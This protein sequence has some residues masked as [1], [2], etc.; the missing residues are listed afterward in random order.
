MKN[1]A[2]TVHMP[3]VWAAFRF[4]RTQVSGKQGQGQGQLTV[5]R[6]PHAWRTGGRGGGQSAEMLATSGPHARGALTALPLTATCF[7]LWTWTVANTDDHRISQIT[8][9]HEKK[10]TWHQNSR[11]KIR[12]GKKT[13]PTYSRV[14]LENAARGAQRLTRVILQ[15]RPILTSKLQNPPF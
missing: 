14:V 10:K 13:P 3:S 5:A 2:V 6:T 9:P 12:E 1:G 15:T 7:S 8:K 4:G 11:C